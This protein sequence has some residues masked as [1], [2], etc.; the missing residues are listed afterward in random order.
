MKT[1]MKFDREGA[2]KAVAELSSL[3]VKAQ[4]E[5]REGVS[6]SGAEVDFYAVYA[7]G[8]QISTTEVLSKFARRHK[9][10]VARASAQSDRVNEAYSRFFEEEKIG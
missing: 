10:S 6:S 3:G 9:K 8:V 7:N 1:N 4:F 2:E 5:H